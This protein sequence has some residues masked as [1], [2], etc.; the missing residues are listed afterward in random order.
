MR[1]HSSIVSFVLLALGACGQAASSYENVAALPAARLVHTTFRYTDE[2][3]SQIGVVP[4]PTPATAK[5]IIAWDE[6]AMGTVARE[7][8]PATTASQIYAILAVAERDA[9]ALSGGV[10]SAE[11]ID[12]IASGI[13]CRFAAFSCEDIR[14]HARTT[15][16]SDPLSALILR[17]VDARLAQIWGPIPYPEPPRGEFD[18]AGRDAVTP[19]AGSWPRWVNAPF[20]AVRPPPAVG[21]AEDI[22][23]ILAVQN[24]VDHVTPTQQSSIAAWIG[25]GGTETPPGMW[26]RRA[27]AL[28]E[29]N[30][31]SLA[32][33]LT[34]RARLTIA[35]ADATVACWR[36]KFAFWTAHPS[37]RDVSITPLLAVPSIPSFP[38]GHATISAA[39]AEVLASWD[40]AHAPTYYGL[41]N[42]SANSRVWAGLQFPVDARAGQQIGSAIARQVLAGDNAPS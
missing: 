18:W 37:E 16:D 4:V 25:G 34:L 2:E 24:A 20:P 11:V 40:L 13:L 6:I 31:S 27:D 7:S 32:D 14:R 39:A 41:S 21:S 9:A 1:R 30:E 17:K 33:V 5:Q 35:M 38:S 15:A 42:Q 22:A 29:T 26:L 8:I 10:P 19:T 23:E 28:L 36:T 12:R 3:R